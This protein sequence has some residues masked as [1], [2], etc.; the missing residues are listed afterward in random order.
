MTAVR[1]TRHL[2][3]TLWR[4][5]ITRLRLLGIASTVRH[6][7]IHVGAAHRIS[8]VWWTTTIRHLLLHLISTSSSERRLS[9]PSPPKPPRGPLSDALSTRMVRPSN[10]CAESRKSQYHPF[11]QKHSQVTA[12]I[13]GTSYSMLFIAEMAFWA[14]ASWVYRTK[15]KPRLRPVSR[16]FTTTYAN[17]FKLENSS[18]CGR[19]I[20]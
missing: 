1:I 20:A 18:K 4:G 7:G 13:G 19:T 11:D 6:R 17:N 16:S 2:E 15:P 12:P 5:A 3:P 9:S 10:L 14:S 8:L